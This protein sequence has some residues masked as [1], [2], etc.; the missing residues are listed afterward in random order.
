MTAREIYRSV[1]MLLDEG[2][3]DFFSKGD[4]EYAINQAQL[5]LIEKL[6]AQSDELG[7]RPY[8]EK[9]FV[10]NV[11]RYS[12]DTVSYPRA[13]NLWVSDGTDYEFYSTLSYIDYSLQTR[14][15]TP[16]VITTDGTFTVDYYTLYPSTNGTTPI[17]VL[18]T[19]ISSTSTLS[20]KLDF[21]YIK[22]PKTFAIAALEVNDVNVKALSPY[23]PEIIFNAAEYLNN[24]D[25]MDYDRSEIAVQQM[26]QR[27]T[28]KG[29]GNNV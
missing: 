20:I 15:W 18:A 2:Y 29:I 16:R 6:V 14:L 27:I 28:M 11:T 4:I 8:Y 17:K 19:N 24:I 3:D 7:L 21:A 12:V 9:D 26:G 5:F 13:C 25:V 23:I 10:S 1:A 22:K